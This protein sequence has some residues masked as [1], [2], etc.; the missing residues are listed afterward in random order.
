MKRSTVVDSVT[1]EIKVDP[2]RTSRQTFLQRGE[3]SVVTKVEERLER[4]TLLP[5]YN[6]E[7]MRGSLLVGEKYSVAPRCGREE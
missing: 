5:W 4:F 2:I 1:G 7:D 6:G 3:I